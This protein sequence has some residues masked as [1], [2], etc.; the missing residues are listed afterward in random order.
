MEK[1]LDT[2][3]DDEDNPIFDEIL[4]LTDRFHRVRDRAIK[5]IGSDK[6][7]DGLMYLMDKACGDC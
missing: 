4:I 3:K 2:V 5:K 1:L 7:V 6:L